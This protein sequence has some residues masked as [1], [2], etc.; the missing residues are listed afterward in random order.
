MG[1]K[2]RQKGWV[3]IRDE[4]VLDSDQEA[5]ASHFRQKQS[6]QEKL[7]RGQRKKMR[8][9]ASDALPAAAAQ[10]HRAGNEGGEEGEAEAESAAEEEE[11]GQGS[12]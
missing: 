12:S 7:G 11:G 10:L 1:Y 5:T 6:E 9:A 8:P 2:K 3:Y 4:L